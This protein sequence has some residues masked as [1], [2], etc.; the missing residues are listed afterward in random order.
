MKNQAFISCFSRYEYMLRA[1]T[2]PPG[3]LPQ[4]TLSCYAIH[5]KGQLA[6]PVA[7]GFVAGQAALAAAIGHTFSAAQIAP[8]PQ[9]ADRCLANRGLAIIKHRD[10]DRGSPTVNRVIAR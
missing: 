5:R 4:G 6:I 8:I 7:V 3:L 9:T 10:G 1:P 2:P